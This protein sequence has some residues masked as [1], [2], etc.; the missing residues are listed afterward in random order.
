[1][2]L[3]TQPLQSSLSQLSQLLSADP[4][5]TQ[6]GSAGMPQAGMPMASYQQTQQNGQQGPISDYLQNQIKSFLSPD[7]QL[8]WQTPNGV[9]G[10]QLPWQTPSGT[11]GLSSL[12]ALFGG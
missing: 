9:A 4:R 11:S 10:P 8:P 3:F 5:H 6:P 12:A 1:M 2:T 7:M